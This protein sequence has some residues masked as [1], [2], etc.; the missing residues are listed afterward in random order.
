MFLLRHSMASA[1]SSV[2]MMATSSPLQQSKKLAGKVAIVTASTDGIGYA[3]AERLGVDGAHVV[4]SSRKQGNVER[5]VRSLESKGCSVLGFPCHVA[6]D[7]DRANLIAKTVEKFGGIDILVS[8]AAVNP[9]VGGVLDCPPGVWDKIFEV[10]VKNALQLSQLVVPEMQKRN[11]GAIVYVSSIAGFQ[12]MPLLG[13]YSVSKTALLGL[14]KAVAQQVASD[15]IRVNCLAPGIVQTKFSSA[16]TENDAVH[17][18]I[19]EQ[20]PLGRV[21][22]PHEMAGI[23]SFLVS[24]DASYVTGES[25]VVA[26]GMTSRL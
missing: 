14:T 13:A 7:E 2:R 4:I 8:N 25:F 19:L 11:G 6:K 26:G 17:E 3:I 24:D 21:A 23:I 5:A 1:F 16:L 10:N 12:P 15:N 22:Q 20:I 9:T 18:K